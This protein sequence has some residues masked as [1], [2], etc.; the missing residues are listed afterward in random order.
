MLEISRTVEE[1]TGY[2]RDALPDDLLTS[3]EPFILRGLVEDWPLVRMGRE[4]NADACKYVMQFYSGAPVAVTLG[5]PALQGRVFYNE[6]FSGINA[7]Q[8]RTQLGGVLKDIL[9]Y[10][11]APEPPLLYVGSTNI[12]AYLP[13]FRDEN[14]VP[15]GD[16]EALASIWI[17]NRTRIAAHYDLPDNLACVT[18]GKRRFTLFPPDQLANLYIGPLDKTPAGQ[19]IS[20][21]DFYNPDFDKFPKFREALKTARVAELEPGDALFVPSMWWHHVE[22]FSPMNIL[23]N[24]WWRQSPLYLAPPRDA[25]NFAILAMRD[26]PPEQRNIW[27]DMFNYYVFDSD[28]E[29]FA[30]IPESGRGILAPMNETLARRIRAYLLNRLNN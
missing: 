15:L 16:R 9:Q 24:Y 2:T 10:A 3:P 25:L 22:A 4:S 23:V 26:L 5:A 17:G 20:L 21:V 29:T 13:G 19:A 6:D 30:H 28:A 12:D 27:R 18:L 14:D 8:I 11:D 7:E 1:K